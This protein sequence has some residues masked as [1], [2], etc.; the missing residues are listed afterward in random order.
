MFEELENKVVFIIGVVIEIG[1]FI[2]ENFGKV[3]VKVVINYC[4]DWYYDEIEEIK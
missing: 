1:K 3:K 4:F 2:V